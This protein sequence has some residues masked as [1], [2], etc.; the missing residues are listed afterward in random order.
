M[1]E[2]VPKLGTCTRMY[3]TY[4]ATNETGGQETKLN[5]VNFVTSVQ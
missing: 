3:A 1:Y 5:G 2:S 4:T